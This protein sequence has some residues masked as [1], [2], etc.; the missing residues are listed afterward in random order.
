VALERGDPTAAVAQAALEGRCAL[1]ERAVLLFLGAY[2]AETGNWALRT[3][4]TGGVWLGGGV[5]RKLLVGPKGTSDAWRRRA[6]EVFL[7]RF[8]D[9][10]RLSSLLEGI[11]VHV[12]V[13]DEAPLLGAAQFAL[14]EVGR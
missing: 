11:P 5:A 8:R 9:K 4:A 7:T 10:G 6:R 3:M 14:S 12:I 13:S 2:G 1:A